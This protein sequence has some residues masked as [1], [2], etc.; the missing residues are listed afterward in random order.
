[1]T[2]SDEAVVFDLHE[3][4]EAAIPSVSHGTTK[5]HPEAFLPCTEAPVAPLPR[6]RPSCP[7]L[8]CLAS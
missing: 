6:N 8:P 1:M 5:P 2:R 7:R 3:F 4:I